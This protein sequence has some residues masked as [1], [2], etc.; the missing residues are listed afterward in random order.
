MLDV[1]YIFHDDMVCLPLFTWNGRGIMSRPKE[2]R[3]EY[4][5]TVNYEDE[6]SKSEG[7]YPPVVVRCNKKPIHAATAVVLTAP[8][9]VGCN[10]DISAVGKLE[11]ESYVRLE[12]LYRGTIAE[13]QKENSEASAGRALL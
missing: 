5:A 8:G 1:L 3:R 9:T 6:T 12:A 13:S 11:K 10:E 7:F 4:V 2:T